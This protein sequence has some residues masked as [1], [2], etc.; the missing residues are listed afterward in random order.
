LA[1]LLSV[2]PFAYSLLVFISS[3]TPITPF[4]NGIL[5]FLFF[6]TLA[7]PTYHTFAFLFVYQLTPFMNGILIFLFFATLAHP[8]YHTFA[9]LFVYQLT[10][11]MNNSVLFRT[12]SFAYA[13]HIAFVLHIIK[14]LSPL[15]DKS[16]IFGPF[17]PR[18]N[19]FLKT[20]S[21]RFVPWTSP[22]MLNAVSLLTA[23]LTLSPLS[24]FTFVALEVNPVGPFV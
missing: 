15:M 4:M 6:A 23:S 16:G 9:F 20:I 10:P 11:G 1:P 22:S 3:R 13:R 8:T 2:A 17:T 21:I 12:V 7:H 19:M 5:I 14:P 18:T 24:A